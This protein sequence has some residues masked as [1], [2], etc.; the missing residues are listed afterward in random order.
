MDFEKFKQDLLA[1]RKRIDAIL[2]AMGEQPSRPENSNLKQPQASSVQPKR[3]LSQ[4]AKNKIAAAQ[5]ARWK[6]RRTKSNHRA[7]AA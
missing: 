5:R 3:K 6:E 7:K 1:E 2:D 4:A